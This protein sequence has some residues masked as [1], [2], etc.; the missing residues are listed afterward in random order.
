MENITI[1][2]LK[3]ESLVGK[4]GPYNRVILA[5]SMGRKISAMGSWADNWK[6][7]DTVSV[8]I[9]TANGTDRNGN[10]VVYTNAKNPNPK[11]APNFSNASA[12]PSQDNTL[13]MS[14]QIASTLLPFLCRDLKRQ[15][16]LKDLD[17]LATQIKTRISPVSIQQKLSTP[18][19]PEVNLDEE[20]VAATQNVVNADIAQE[21][22]EDERPF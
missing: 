22:E 1:T 13:V 16:T 10:P 15:A 7:G 18:V 19:V 21:E 4:F 3:R 2:Q 17:D 12:K 5:D 6:V 20:T 14:Y 9:E 8:N 11:T